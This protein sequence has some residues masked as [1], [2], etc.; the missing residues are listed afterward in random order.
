MLQKYK[1]IIAYDGTDYFGW[2]DQKERPSIAGTLQA[3]FKK[4]FNRDIK[5]HD[6]SR[7]DA[8]VH[9]MGQVGSFSTDLGIDCDIMLHA[10]NNVLPDDIVIQLLQKVD[11][12]LKKVCA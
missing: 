11:D 10:W 5:M 9:A 8:G 12:V 4:V 1:I 6:V 7:T 2:Q 3:T